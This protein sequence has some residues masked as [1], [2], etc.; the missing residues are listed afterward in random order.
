MVGAAVA[1][2]TLL[3]IILGFLLAAAYV[4]VTDRTASRNGATTGSQPTHDQERRSDSDG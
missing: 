2:Y 4:W 3:S 1:D